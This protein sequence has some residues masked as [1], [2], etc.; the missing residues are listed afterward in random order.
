MAVMTS[1]SWRS[2]RAMAFFYD[3]LDDVY[4]LGQIR[5]A[6]F[7]QI[8]EM[9]PGDKVLYA[10]PGT[11]RAAVW[12]ARRGVQLTCIDIS[13]AMLNRTRRSLEREGFSAELILDDV[14]NHRRPAYYD[15]V[16]ANFFL[17]VF[18]EDTMR[19][20]LAH[21]ASLVTPGGK[22]LTADYALPKGN[23]FSRTGHAFYWRASNVFNWVICSSALHPIYDYPAYFPEAGLELKEIKCFR[24]LK[25][26]PAFFQ[27]TTALRRV[28]EHLADDP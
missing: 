23:I 20:V 22:L 25:I 7:S 11:G 12:A 19:R 5:A 2:G 17:N 4:S 27:S 26:G 16:V 9:R 1:A 14:L 13:S 24:L 15:K 6:K 21:V 28:P 8:A 3:L 18:S 10:G